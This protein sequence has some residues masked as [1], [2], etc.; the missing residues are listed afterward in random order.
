VD[1]PSWLVPVARAAGLRRQ[2]LTFSYLV[3]RKDR[4]RLADSLPVRPGAT[5]L[6]VV[7]DVM[8]SKGKLESFV[9]GELGSGAS[10]AV[11]R[12]RVARLHRDASGKNVAWKRLSRGDLIVVEPAPSRERP[13]ID[14]ETS[15]SIASERNE[16]R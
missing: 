8:A 14:A 11:A 4:A 15:V 3:V 10:L 1:L 6:R 12:A 13:R 2:G 5:R 9:C 7:S 16:S